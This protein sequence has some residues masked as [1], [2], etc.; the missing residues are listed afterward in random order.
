M[1]TVTVPLEITH[2][3]VSEIVLVHP[4]SQSNTVIPVNF[5]N[6]PSSILSRV[7]RTVPSAEREERSEPVRSFSSEVGTEAR[8]A[9]KGTSFF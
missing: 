3:F 5:E 2:N 8:R 9:E 6:K 1:L 4:V 7:S